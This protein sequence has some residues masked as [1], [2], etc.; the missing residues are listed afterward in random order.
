MA[1]QHRKIDPPMEFAHRCWAAIRRHPWRL[2]WLLPVVPLCI[3]AYVATLVPL[4]P[5]TQ[6]IR[7]VREQKPSVLVSED[8]QVL[9]T[10]RRTNREWVKLSEIS[11]KVVDA[12]IATVV[13]CFFE[14][15][16]L[17]VRRTISAAFH[18]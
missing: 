2:L 7:T 5:S 17:D 16:G 13:L 4:T 1:E 11:P 6:D 12:L 14:H 3:A 8:G 18:T 10:F 15:S 9:A